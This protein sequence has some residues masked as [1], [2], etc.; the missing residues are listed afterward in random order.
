GPARR[1]ETA[2]GR[3]GGATWQYSVAFAYVYMRGTGP[4]R[5]AEG[6][7]LGQRQAARVGAAQLVQQP[8]LARVPGQGATARKGAGLQ[9]V[10]GR[11]QLGRDRH[12]FQFAQGRL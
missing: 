1:P 12:R 6:G 11:R 2:A 9:G 3:S 10:Q 5:S 8:D 4:A 7:P